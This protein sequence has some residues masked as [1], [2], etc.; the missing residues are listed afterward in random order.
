LAAAIKKAGLRFVRCG[1]HALYAHVCFR[2]AVR[3]LPSKRLASG[4]YGAG[5]TRFAHMFAS[6]APFGCC[7]QKG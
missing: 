4:A 7:H 2:G 6:A 3:L 1:K 5:S